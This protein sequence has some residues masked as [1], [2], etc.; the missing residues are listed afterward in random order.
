[1]MINFSSGSYRL[2]EK[3]FP[4]NPSKQLHLLVSS[5]GHTV[6]YSLKRQ[7]VYFRISVHV[8]DIEKVKTNSHPPSPPSCQFPVDHYW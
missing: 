5:S 8:N 2:T 6:S 4:E 1:M 3:S 7:D